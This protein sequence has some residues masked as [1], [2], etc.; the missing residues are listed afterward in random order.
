M[1]QRT[2]EAHAMSR[3]R[4]KSAHL[5]IEFRGNAH[6][7]GDKRDARASFRAGHIIH[8]REETQILSGAQAS[9]ETLV[10]AGV[11]AKMA[12]RAGRLALDIASGDR[13]AAV[14]R[15]NQRGENA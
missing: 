11:V 7:F 10:A 1:E 3:A 5:A 4:R 9:V 6:A 8:G 15:K 13:R 12:P 14:C 2:R